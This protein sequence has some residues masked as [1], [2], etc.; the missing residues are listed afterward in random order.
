M[1]NKWNSIGATDKTEELSPQ[2]PPLIA[3]M[4]LDL[5]ERTEILEFTY[6]SRVGA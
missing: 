3:P 5:V 6:E 1:K 4:E 2:V